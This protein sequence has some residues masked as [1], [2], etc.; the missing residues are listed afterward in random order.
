ME[1]CATCC[2]AAVQ[3]KQHLSKVSLMSVCVRVSI[4]SR[5]ARAREHVSCSLSRITLSLPRT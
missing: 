2:L 1:Y 3:E 4:G 5:F